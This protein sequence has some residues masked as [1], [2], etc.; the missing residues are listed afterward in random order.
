MAV[1]EGDLPTLRLV[2]SKP[3]AAA[4]ARRWPKVNLAHAVERHLAGGD[5]L[6]DEQF[7]VLHAT[8]RFPLV[9]VPLPPGR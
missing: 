9:V 3:A 2:W 6:T 7:I 8:G 5:G 4:P 1:Q